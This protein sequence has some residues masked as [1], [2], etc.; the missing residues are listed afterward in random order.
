MDF[1]MTE[2]DDFEGSPITQSE[3]G[4]ASEAIRPGKAVTAYGL[5][6]DMLEVLREMEGGGGD[7]DCQ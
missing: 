3:E 6:V 4:E 7:G 2:G 1:H 5:A